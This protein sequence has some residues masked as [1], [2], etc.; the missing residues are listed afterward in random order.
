MIPIN[1]KSLFML[2]DVSL[3]FKVEL[4]CAVRVITPPVSNPIEHT[5]NLLRDDVTQ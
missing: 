4:F 1:Y 5:G 2:F 3:T